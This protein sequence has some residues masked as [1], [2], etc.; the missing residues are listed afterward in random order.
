MSLR[1]IA[2]FQWAVFKLDIRICFPPNFLEVCVKGDGSCD[3]TCR[4]QYIDL[5]Q[6]SS[7]SLTVFGGLLVINLISSQ[8]IVTFVSFLYL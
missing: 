6:G 7:S 5:L 8:K 4:N 3:F 2:D 1:V